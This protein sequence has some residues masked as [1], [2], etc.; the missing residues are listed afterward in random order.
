LTGDAAPCLDAQTSAV[1]ASL[2]SPP[3]P[4]EGDHQVLLAAIARGRITG[5]SD[6]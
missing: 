1:I 5:E 3:D 4:N 2:L 6:V